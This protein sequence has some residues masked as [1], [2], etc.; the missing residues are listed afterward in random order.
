MDNL[1]YFIC[2][3]TASGKT[4]LSVSLASALH[5]DVLSFDSRQFFK[6]MS[7]GTAV[8]TDKEMGGVKHHFIHQRSIKDD[9]NAGIFETEAIALLTDLFKTKKQIV[10]VGG[11]GLYLDALTKGFVEMEAIPNEIRS[12]LNAL[13]KNE[14]IDALRL[15]LS[16]KDPEYFKIV[17]VHNPHRLIRALEV[18]EYTG[19]KFSKQRKHQAKKRSFK[20]KKFA[21]EWDRS[22]L[23]E[24]IDLRVLKMIDNGLIKEVE[25]LLPFR[26][27][28]ALA[29]VGY[30]E[31][32]DYL[33]G[34][35]SLDTAIELIQ[36]NSRRYAKRQ[37]TWLRRDS[38]V[39]WLKADETKQMIK[40]ILT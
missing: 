17:D 4:D 29:S 12:E 13:F 34:T 10:A 7:I 27:H 2:G 37:L 32:F 30:Q 21:I 1:L 18:I 6:E 25:S 20:W 11:S 24:R 14:G 33:D 28:R 35:I 23:Y 15:L 39:I 38:E 5:T 40:S 26:D 16:K 36:R 31:L 9:Y 8:P 19:G 22:I 3:P